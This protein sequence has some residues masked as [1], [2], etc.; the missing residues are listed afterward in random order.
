MASTVDK[1]VLLTF[2]WITSNHNFPGR[3]AVVIKLKEI[4]TSSYRYACFNF[5]SFDFLYH[6][7]KELAKIYNLSSIDKLMN[8]E[9]PAKLRYEEIFNYP[10]IFT[11]LIVPE[12]KIWPFAKAQGYFLLDSFD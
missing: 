6:C 3:Y 8:S 9:F 7:L 1:D 12:E 4:E 11:A 10:S 5:Y 2:A